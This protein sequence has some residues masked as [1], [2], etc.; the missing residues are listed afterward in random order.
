[1]AHRRYRLTPEQ[2]DAAVEEA[3]ELIP[4]QFSEALANVAVLV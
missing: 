1:M 3:L 2:F 4:A